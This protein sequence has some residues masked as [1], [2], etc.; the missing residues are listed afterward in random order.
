M[1]LSER[2]ITSF[3]ELGNVLKRCLTDGCD[4]RLNH[5]INDAVLYNVWFD[6]KNV[7]LAFAE[8]VPILNYESLSQWCNMVRPSANCRAILSIDGGR[9]PLECF[10]EMLCTLLSGNRWICR[11]PERDSGLMHYVAGLLNDIDAG[12]GSRIA[13]SKSIVKSF[14]AVIIPRDCNDTVRSYLENYNHV[15]GDDGRVVAVLDG[16]EK[17][18][19]LEQLADDVFDYFGLGC[20]S[21]SK[22]Y[23]PVGY[24]FS[25]LMNAFSKR[26]S[27]LI[28]NS[29]YLNNYEYFKS[30]WMLNGD[31]LFDNGS[32][33]LRQS[34][35]FV[36]APSF[37]NFEYFENLDDLSRIL[38]SQTESIRVVESGFLKGNSVP[39]GGARLGKLSDY[40]RSNRMI[41]LLNNL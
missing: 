30:V 34:D 37:V 20:N 9:V 7:S 11:L 10:P 25:R 6:R 12:L 13:F 39:F 32:M 19:E 40:Y 26:S 33:L 29:H 18:T 38:D 31:L 5:I 27:A 36:S 21:V 16:N 17:Q 15:K 22:L 24:D 14:D 1:N 23:V 28:D 4:D 35:D 3:V 8:V 2:D 41:E